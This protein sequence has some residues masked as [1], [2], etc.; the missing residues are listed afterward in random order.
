MNEP[1]TSG[2][3]DPLAILLVE[4]HPDM[5]LALSLFLERRGYSARTASTVEEALVQL[6]ATPFD[7]LI[8]DTRLPDGDGWEMLERANLPDSVYTIAMTGDGARN[9]QE[10]SISAGYRHNLVK[11]FDPA[12]LTKLLAEAG[13][14]C[15]ARRDA[16]LCAAAC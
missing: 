16:G 12:H 9:D 14:E 10:R 6:A 15:A 13:R 8:A 5:A 11:P 2:A 1:E 7:V 3:R 4:N